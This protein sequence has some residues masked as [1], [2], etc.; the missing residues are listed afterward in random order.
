MDRAIWTQE[1]EKELLGFLLEHKAEAGDGVN[2]KQ[3][4]WNAAAAALAKRPHKGAV[5]S[6]NS[7]KNKW[8]KVSDPIHSHSCNELMEFAVEGNIS[9]CP[10]SL[11]SIRFQLGRGPRCRYRASRAEC[12]G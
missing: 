7:C 5:K 4:T 8:T 6:A 3:T 10:H 1:D 2:F 11:K 12:L 9:C